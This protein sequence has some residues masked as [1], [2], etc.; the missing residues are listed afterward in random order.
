MGMPRFAELARD[1]AIADISASGNARFRTN[2]TML[3]KTMAVQTADTAVTSSGS[4]KTSLSCALLRVSKSRA[5]LATKNVRALRTWRALSPRTLWRPTNQ[6]TMMMN[7]TTKKPCSTPTTKSLRGTG[8]GDCPD[9]H[10]GYRAALLR[11]N[12]GRLRPGVRHS[13]GSF[14]IWTILLSLST[15]ITFGA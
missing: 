12:G 2:F 6:P 7:Q 3:K 5:G 11:A 8:G 15:W 9:S 14:P 4:A 10:S 13:A 1:A